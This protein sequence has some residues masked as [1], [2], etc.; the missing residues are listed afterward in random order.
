[1]LPHENGTKTLAHWCE[2]TGMVW[3][4]SLPPSCFL[5]C[6]IIVAYLTFLTSKMGEVE[7]ICF[8]LRKTGVQVQLEPLGAQVTL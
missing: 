2:V 8:G 4:T 6:L 5:V 1:M 7:A 3:V